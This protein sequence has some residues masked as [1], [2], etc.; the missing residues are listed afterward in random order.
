MRDDDDDVCIP[1]DA[2]LGAPRGIDATYTHI[3][4]RVQDRERAS[5]LRSS[6]TTRTR[7]PTA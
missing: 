1:R 6:S 2:S 3:N 4:R 7:H 5:A